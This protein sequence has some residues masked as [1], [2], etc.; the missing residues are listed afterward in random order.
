MGFGKQGKGVIIY[1]QNIDIVLG[2]LAS[3]AA[4]SENGPVL[5]DGFRLLKTEGFV[6]ADGGTDGRPVTFGICQADMTD[7]EIAVCLLSAPLGRQAIAAAE[8]S[9]RP[10]FVMGVVQDGEVIRFI[11]EDGIKQT[12]WTFPEDS[13]GWAWFGFNPF[14]DAMQ[15]GTVLQIRAKHYGVWV[16]E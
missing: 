11:P 7:A 12:Q 4:L 9:Q 13:G 5:T 1:E 2:T 16:G 6:H 14:D 15:A 10:C 8:T 3:R